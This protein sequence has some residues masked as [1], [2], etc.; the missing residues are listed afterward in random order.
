MDCILVVNACMKNKLQANSLCNLKHGL[1]R[2]TCQSRYD[3][4]LPSCSILAYLFRHP[5][6]DDSCKEAHRAWWCYV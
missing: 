1:I 5:S 4:D 2:Q 6:P 3:R